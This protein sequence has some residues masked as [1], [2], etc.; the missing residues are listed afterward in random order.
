MKVRAGSSAMSILTAFGR[1]GALNHWVALL[2]AHEA[3]V[4]LAFLQVAPLQLAH[5]TTLG[6]PLSDVQHERLQRDAAVGVCATLQL[7]F[8]CAFTIC[9]A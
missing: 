6:I 5:L 3:A 7:A 8:L 1:K 4:K 2:V 9:V